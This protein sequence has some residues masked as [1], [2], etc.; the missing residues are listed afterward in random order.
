[1][2]DLITWIVAFAIVGLLLVLRIRAALRDRKWA[3]ENPSEAVKRWL[4]GGL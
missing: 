3:K 1:M 4:N 2:N